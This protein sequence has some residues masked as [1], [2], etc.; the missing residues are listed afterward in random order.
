MLP[1]GCGVGSGAGVG[2]GAGVNTV[3]ELP[4]ASN[5]ARSGALSC[6]SSIA[7]AHQKTRSAHPRSL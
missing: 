1:L 4:I 5:M 7:A 3:G 6:R 2:A